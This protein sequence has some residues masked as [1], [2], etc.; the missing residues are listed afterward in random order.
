MNLKRG[1]VITLIFIL[2]SVSVDAKTIFKENKLKN[3]IVLFEN[4]REHTNTVSILISIKGGLFRED[5]KNNGIGYLM[6]RVSLKSNKIL[7]TA[8]F[9]GASISSGITSYSTEIVLSAPVDVIPKLYPDFKEFILSPKFDKSI[10]AR[11]KESVIKEIISVDDDPNSIAYN[12]FNSL[13]NKGLPYAM[14][15]YGTVET[16]KQLSLSDIIEDR[17]MLMLDTQIVVSVVGNYNDK[18]LSELKSILSSIDTKSKYQYECDNKYKFKSERIE[19]TDSRIEQSKLYMAYKAPSLDNKY[20]TATKVLTELLGGGMSSRYFTEIRKNLGFAYSVGAGYPTRVCES[21]FIISSGLEYANIDKAIKKIDDINFNLAK[22]VT[23]E[24]LDKAKNALLGS[25][26]I[27]SQTN[28]ELARS[29][30]LY[31]VLSSEKNAYD[32]YVNNIKKVTKSDIIKAAEMLKGDRLIYI[33][34]PSEK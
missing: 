11:E 3:G 16:Q 29:R 23:D 14:T 2:V 24:E 34:K 7:D 27:G 12:R 19:D 31:E 17:K 4:K 26:L 10:F 22:T 18:I 9:Y 5:S 15:T 30:S 20:Y 1:I 21:R 32:T 8:E 25:L 33:L 13:S 6:N 28:F